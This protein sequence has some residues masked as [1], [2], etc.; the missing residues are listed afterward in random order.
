MWF[1]RRICHHG[2]PEWMIWVCM[3]V[4]GI[5]WV[6]AQVPV[7]MSAF[8]GVSSSPCAKENLKKIPSLAQFF[9]LHSSMEECN[10]S[11]VHSMTV[12]WLFLLHTNG[13]LNNNVQCKQPLM[14]V[15]I[16]CYIAWSSFAQE[17]VSWC[18]VFNI[19]LVA[20]LLI[21]NSSFLMCA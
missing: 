20:L 6:G 1:I 4:R 8:R 10:Q 5:M 3:C 19:L 15:N 17:F 21:Q 13:A 7:C 14:W 12:S 9:P 2:T 18:F 16:P 11:E